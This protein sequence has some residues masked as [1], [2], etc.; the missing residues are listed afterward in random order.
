MSMARIWQPTLGRAAPR[1]VSLL[2]RVRAQARDLAADCW[3]LPRYLVKYC[4]GV[5]AVFGLLQVWQASGDGPMPAFRSLH[6]AKQLDPFCTSHP[7]C[8]YAETSDSA[9]WQA[10]A[11]AL[12]ILDEVNP[13]VAAWVRGAHREGKLHFTKRARPRG[14]ATGQLGEYDALR[15]ELT[16]FSGLFAENDGTIAAILCHEYRHS[17]QRFPKTLVYALSFLVLENGDPAIIENDALLYE[18]EANLAI[19]GQYQTL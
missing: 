4:M 10:L 1:E 13:E 19:F 3:N 7:R 17:R 16:V 12:A 2:V 11:P 15:G 5:L 18:Q 14:R 8:M 6:P 9:R